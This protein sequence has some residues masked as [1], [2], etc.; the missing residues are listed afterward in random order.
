M[1]VF[2]CKKWPIGG[3][4][5][6][7]SFQNRAWC[8]VPTGR[9]MLSGRCFQLRTMSQEI[10]SPTKS[11]SKLKRWLRAL[12]LGGLG[13]IILVGVVGWMA[14]LKIAN[15]LLAN[16]LPNFPAKVGSVDWKN[17]GVELRNLEI[18]GRAGNASII[19]VPR[20]HL[21]AGSRI[22]EG[23][24]G[25]LTLESPVISMDQEFLT[26]LQSGNDSVPAEVGPRT[27]SEA[28]A[29]D[30]ISFASVEIQNARIVF[31]GAGERNVSA[32]LNWTGGS[33]AMKSDG[34][35]RAERQNISVEEVA[36]S[37]DGKSAPVAAKKL[38]L[39][40]S[41]DDANRKLTIHQF[42]TGPLALPLGNSFWKLIDALPKAAV[43][44]SPKESGSP[45]MFDQVV[46][47][48]VEIGPVQFSLTQ[49]PWLPQLPTS[50]GSLVIKLQ[51]VASG[52]SSVPSKGT[53]LAELSGFDLADPSGDSFVAIPK[54]RVEGGFADGGIRLANAE[55]SPFTV[56]V[57]RAR[58]KAWGLPDVALN[59][60]V[61]LR[62]GGLIWKD[63]GIRSQES[64]GLT[65]SDVRLKLGDSAHDALQWNSFELDG[66]VEEILEQKRFRKLTLTK[67]VV[68][69]KGAD[70]KVMASFEGASP[71]SIEPAPA[72]AMAGVW[73]GWVCDDP[74]I[75]AGS[76]RTEQLGAGIPDMTG[77][78]ELMTREGD[79]H[80][81]LRE[82]VVS[83]PD[84]PLAPPLFHGS[85]LLVQIDPEVL[86]N[87]RRIKHVHLRGSRLQIGATETD[88]QV[89]QS[90]V[91]VTERQGVAELPKTDNSPVP[92]DWHIGELE[93]ED[94]KIF[95][96]HLVPDTS[97]VLVPLA[98]KT[99]FNL[100]LTEEGLRESTRKE[101]IELPFVYVPGTRAGTSVADLD[102]N[103]VHFSLAG[104]MRKEID[105]VELVNPK[106]YV[107]D[108]LF[109]YVEK[110]RTPD[111]KVPV[112]PQTVS[113]VRSMISS[114]V[115]VLMGETP[116]PV[117]Q[118][119]WSIDRV[120]AING[121][122]I[123]TVKDSP[124]FRVPPLPFGADSS[125]K[126]SQINAELAVPPGIYKPVMGLE[127][128]VSVSQGAIAFNLPTK[129]TSNNLVQVFKADWIR[130]KQFRIADVT[131]EVTY[132]KNG[133][134]A[135]FWAKGYQ[136]DLEGA[137]NLYLDDN[138]SWDMWLSGTNI[139]TKEIT[140]K[141]SP[142]SFSMKGRIDF[143]VIAQGDKTSL[144]QATGSFKNRD[145]G[146]IKVVAV[147]DL[148]K[149]LPADWNEAERKW[150][151]KIMEVLRD[152]SYSK[153]E[154]DL[155][156]YG[157]EG[158]IHLKLNGPDGERNFDVFSHDRRLKPTP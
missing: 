15:S 155:R 85:E 119:G 142:A 127:L 7:K 47:E 135:K 144:Y 20:A 6:L 149:S 100:P 14:R 64:M 82:M 78:L 42:H 154:G 102:T 151:T 39:D 5:W 16:A 146:K 104:L 69:L 2:G 4:G 93:I 25:A 128:V 88:S 48:D 94:T 11:T 152:F 141:L 59:G 35:L 123:T 124:L 17:G 62:A 24:L 55:I 79:W 83:T 53:V 131:L 49:I 26:Q 106:I 63:G 77:N 134:Y 109:H 1:E 90:V 150:V 19:T 92:R 115:T 31:A 99:F 122:L 138:L 97:D 121:K 51:N 91:E 33:V 132:D 74:R 156:F 13:G 148:I 65:V 54:V 50:H 120:K 70:L 22:T 111:P 113:E 87:E 46:L 67:P 125:V 95:L 44:T 105:A 84:I 73:E 136:G 66:R 117:T 23:K 101:R 157:L 3:G 34:S 21:S 45:P 98:H 112:V 27:K 140:D 129:E 147:D 40:V 56:D 71:Q 114:L 38:Q 36:V 86:W 37:I 18:R 57:S 116:P 103:F 110:I 137:F 118:H 8:C 130:F 153:C 29:E 89:P 158:Q 143:K 133:A 60:A 9:S 75:V 61:A 107:G 28:P 139:E 80:L 68:H 108:S 41:S 126:H 32:R 145:T 10:P 96:H 52:L 58:A 43:E 72:P 12:L 81:S 76:I 30:S